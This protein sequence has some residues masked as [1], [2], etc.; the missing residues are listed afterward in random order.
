MKIYDELNLSEV[1]T[2]AG[3]TEVK[4]V[5]I[6]EGL[7]EEFES[8][9]DEL[10]PDGLSITELNDLLWFDYKYIFDCLGIEYDEE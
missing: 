1:N 3:A 10:F 7:E 6:N 5:I 9:I 8:L 2:W 4:N